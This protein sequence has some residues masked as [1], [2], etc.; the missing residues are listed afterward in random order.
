MW[1]ADRNRKLFFWFI[2]VLI[3]MVERFVARAGQRGRVS[4]LF[5]LLAAVTPVA[6]AG[7]VCPLACTSLP[8]SFAYSLA[9]TAQTFPLSSPPSTCRMSTC[10][11]LKSSW[12][13]ENLNRLSFARPRSHHYHRCCCLFL[14]S[15]LFLLHCSRSPLYVIPE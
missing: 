12:G 7:P 8:F 13:K 11:D 14:S 3:R 9:I 15:R 10:S 5:F 6:V 4:M 2:V 1:L